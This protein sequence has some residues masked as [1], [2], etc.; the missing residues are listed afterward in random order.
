[1]QVIYLTTIKNSKFG[2][3]FM[4]VYSSHC[5]LATNLLSAQLMNPGNK[6]LH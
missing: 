2:L 5:S 4:L 1:M 6:D 3:S